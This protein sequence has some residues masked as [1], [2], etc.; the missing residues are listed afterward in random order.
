MQRA[1]EK[2]KKQ[3]AK[4]R[5]GWA[6]NPLHFIDSNISKSFVS[7]K[8]DIGVPCRQDGRPP[9]EYAAHAAGP[10]FAFLFVVRECE[11][12]TTYSQ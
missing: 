4:V 7:R 3:I 9:R 6:K 1:H 8:R 11:G 2:P 5:G 10:D 12:K